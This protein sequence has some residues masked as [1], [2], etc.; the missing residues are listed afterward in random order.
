MNSGVDQGLDDIIQQ[1][2]GPRGRAFSGGTGGWQT[3]SRLGR[4]RGGASASTRGGGRG[5]FSTREG[6]STASLARASGM[7]LRENLKKSMPDL[8]AVIKANA[9]PQ[10]PKERMRKPMDIQPRGEGGRGRT[11]SLREDRVGMLRGEQESKAVG[12][13]RSLPAANSSGRYNT[14]TDPKKI[15]VTVPGLSHSRSEVRKTDGIQEP[16]SSRVLLV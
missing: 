7:D 1:K 3:F 16:F 5:S 4:G 6:I 10:L 14:P 11:T 12:A 9:P 13:R 2:R 8:R 15:R